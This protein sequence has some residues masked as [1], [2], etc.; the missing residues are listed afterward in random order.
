LGD[1]IANTLNKNVG[2]GSKLLGVDNEDRFYYRPKEKEREMD[3]DD[4][5]GSVAH[6]DDADRVKKLMLG[7][8][9]NFVFVAQNTSFGGVSGPDPWMVVNSGALF[10]GLQWSLDQVSG[11][12][13]SSPQGAGII[14]QPGQQ[15]VGASGM[16]ALNPFQ[17][18]SGSNLLGKSASGQQLQQ[19]QMKNQ[20][21]VDRPESSGSRVFVL[22]PMPRKGSNFGPFQG[23]MS[24]VFP[25]GSVG[26][27]TGGRV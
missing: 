25:A 23:M 3:K 13:S 4:G 19:V 12:W 1:G 9:P 7:E 14:M 2:A 22:P 10:S 27:S 15:Y 17:V 18:Q 21:G 11:F 16:G 24:S 26:V 20:Q 6:G 8:N 5:F